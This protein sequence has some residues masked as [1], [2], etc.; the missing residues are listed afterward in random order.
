MLKIKKYQILKF[1]IFFA[2]FLKFNILFV[3]YY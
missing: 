2:L 3:L 1:D